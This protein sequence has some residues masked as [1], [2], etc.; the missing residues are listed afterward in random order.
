LI[1]TNE[2]VAVKKIPTEE[3]R[4]AVITERV[5]HAI[6]LYNLFAENS[7][8]KAVC[9]TGTGSHSE[10]QLRQGIAAA[11]D[12]SA[13]VLFSMWV[14][15]EK[16]DMRRFGGLFFT[17]PIRATNKLSQQIGHTTRSFP[18][19]KDGIVLDF[20]DSHISLANLQYLTREE[21]VFTHDDIKEIP[22]EVQYER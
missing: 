11:N 15:D 22:Y 17:C 20:I 5:S 8:V 2:E 3:D 6:R 12:G 7:S 21:C 1:T 4:N 13:N 19:K 14:A 16:L 9:I 10:K 18:K